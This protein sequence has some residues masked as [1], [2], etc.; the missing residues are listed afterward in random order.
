MRFSTVF[1]SRAGLAL[2]AFAAPQKVP[3]T[4]VTF[5]VKNES[6]LFMETVAR[7][8]LSAPEAKIESLGAQQLK[9]TERSDI[10]AREIQS[11]ASQWDRD[12]KLKTIAIYARPEQ[13]PLFEKLIRERYS[14]D[15]KVQVGQACPCVLIKGS[16]A[17]EAANF[18]Q[19]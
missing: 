6:R 4:E 7:L 14:E 11:F 16:K 15:V 9:V 18:A 3:Q 1:Y 8:C 10:C 17:S 2:P 12:P 19:R 13:K 5:A